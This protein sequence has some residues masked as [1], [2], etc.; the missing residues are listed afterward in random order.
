[1]FIFIIPRAITKINI[2]VIVKITI[3]KLKLN[4]KKV[5]ITL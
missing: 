5:Q 2:L 3:D 4:T 1:M